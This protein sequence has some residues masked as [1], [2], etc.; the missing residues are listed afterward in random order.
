MTCSPYSFCRAD[1]KGSGPELGWKVDPS[2]GVG[3]D[4]SQNEIKN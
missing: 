3:D 1:Y 2:V 4:P